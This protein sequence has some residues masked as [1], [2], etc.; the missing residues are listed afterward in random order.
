MNCANC[1][2]PVQNNDF[3]ED[4]YTFCNSLCRYTWRQNGKPNPHI[5][6]DENTLHKT[7]TDFSLDY[8][9]PLPGFEDKEVTI[10][11]S[12]WVGPKLLINNKKIKP[13]KKNIIT[14]NREFVLTSDF[15]KTVY[16]KFKHRL[17][18]IVPK[19]YIDGTEFKIARQLNV[20]EYIWICL[21][22]IL[23]FIGGALGSFIGTIALYS[24]S[25][26]I[27]KPKRVFLKYLL[28]GITTLASFWF[29]FQS[30]GI[31]IPF[32][33]SAMM[34]FSVEKTLK[35][36]SEEVNKQCPMMVDEVTRLDSTEIG[37]DKTFIY[38]YTLTNK[39]K[40]D[41]DLEEMKKFLTYQIIHNVRTNEQ[42]KTMRD[43][44]VSVR[45]NYQ[46]K[47]LEHLFEINVTKEDYN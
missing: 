25:I 35:W 10:R 12:Y 4:G 11:L 7:L 14:K 40:T 47:N 31:V 6:S 5:T 20:W 18:D 24:N 33:E 13:I 42:L 29:F 2:K 43:N 27:R 41:K 28:P 26:L 23:I 9:L 46:D 34:Q 16:I 38:Y 21:P 37:S 22:L 32:M 15:G 3:T 36:E 1:G 17:L 8:S 39:E 44:G 19:V 30:L 45:Y